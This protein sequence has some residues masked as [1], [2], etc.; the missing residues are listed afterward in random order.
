MRKNY[1]RLFE[2]LQTYLLKSM[3][4]WRARNAIR[5]HIFRMTFQVRKRT[6]HEWEAGITISWVHYFS[7]DFNVCVCECVSDRRRTKISKR[8]IK[9][10]TH[11]KKVCEHKQKCEFLRFLPFVRQKRMRCWY[12]VVFLLLFIYLFDT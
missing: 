6:E 12:F 1:L 3:S 9:N 10:R 2:M 4:A 5:S 11:T 8:Q 7:Q